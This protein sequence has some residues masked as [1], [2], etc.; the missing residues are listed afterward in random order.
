MGMCMWCLCRSGLYLDN[1]VGGVCVVGVVCCLAVHEERA[2]GEALTKFN[3]Q[4]QAGYTSATQ[5]K[6]RAELSR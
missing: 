5:P 6:H 4:L 3:F 1:H 2:V